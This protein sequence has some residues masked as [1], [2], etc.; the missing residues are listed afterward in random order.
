MAKF[1]NTNPDQQH[2]LL[3]RKPEGILIGRSSSCDIKITGVDVSSKHSKLSLA[4]NKI[5]DYFFLTDL[6]SNGTFVNG[7]K[8]G[9]GSS[10]LL[11]SGD[12]VSFA[13]T[14][15]VYI[16]RY[17]LDEVNEEN[18]KR[19]LFDDYI[20]GKQLGS[21][22]YAIVKE[23]KN[24]LTG[25]IVAVKIF[26]PNK[27]SK[28]SQEDEAKLQQEIDLLLSIDHPNIVKFINRYVEPINQHSVST[29]L[30]MEKVNSGELFERIINKSKLRED[31]TKALFKQLLSGLFYLH[32]KNIIH[33]DIKPEN[34]LLDI[35]PRQS[36]QQQQ[37]G[38]W[39][40]NEYDIKVKIADFGLAKFIGELQFTNTLCGT[41]AYVAPEILSNQ[42]NYTTKADLWLAGV[43]LYVCLCGFP[44]FSDELAPPNMR[45]QILTAKYAFYSPYWD[46]ITDSALDL[47]SSL[48]VLNPEERYDVTTAADHQWFRD[49]V[50]ED[51]VMDSLD[52]SSSKNSLQRSSSMGS[53]KREP[54]RNDSHPLSFRHKFAS[55]LNSL[56]YQ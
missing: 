40:E 53:V 37:T 54:L 28:D 20:V 2:I 47:I 18:K 44:P 49:E 45:E 36:G 25:D 30:I 41:P 4:N 23:A 15:G 16:F 27:T 7:A 48:L 29:Y 13:K 51:M 21:G 38:P 22:H 14:G 34:I 52:S 19:S 43:L 5:R 17:L 56:L 50:Q 9:H 12:K 35:T 10:V 33:R 55:E 31:E 24:R 6:S 39:D 11:K 46:D 1:Y 32:Q 26:H 8:L 3:P 42:I